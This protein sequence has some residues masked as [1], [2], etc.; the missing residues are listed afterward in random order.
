MSPIHTDVL[1]Q[2]YKNG[3]VFKGC[4]RF[5]GEVLNCVYYSHRKNQDN[6]FEESKFIYTSSFNYSM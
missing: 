5:Q 1:I 4:L 6:L 2:K 3:C